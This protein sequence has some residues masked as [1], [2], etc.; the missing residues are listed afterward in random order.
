M[1]AVLTTETSIEAWPRS[2][3]RTR[4]MRALPVANV[5]GAWQT[6]VPDSPRSPSAPSRRQIGGLNRDRHRAQS[7]TKVAGPPCQPQFIG[8]VR[9]QVRRIGSAVGLRRRASASLLGCE[10]ARSPRGEAA[11]PGQATG[12]P[13]VPNVGVYLERRAWPCGVRLALLPERPA[14]TI[15]LLV[16]LTASRST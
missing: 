3:A 14:R 11:T 7:P 5:K 16:R 6:T 9:R 2:S 13:R 1:A 12:E 10:Q 15:V 8:Q 4:A